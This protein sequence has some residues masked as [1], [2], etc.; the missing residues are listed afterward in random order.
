MYPW[1]TTVSCIQECLIYFIIS[2]I[3]SIQSTKTSLVMNKAWL[4]SLNCDVGYK[5]INLFC[6]YNKTVLCARLSN[7][8]TCL[9]FEAPVYS[10]FC[11]SRILYNPHSPSGSLNVWGYQQSFR[12]FRILECNWSMRCLSISWYWRS[13]K[14]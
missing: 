11:I 3:I 12:V 14:V 8:V 4:C 10:N 9:L 5:R 13:I 1:C 6:H 2:L 7:K